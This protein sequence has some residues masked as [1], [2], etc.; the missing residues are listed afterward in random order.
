MMQTTDLALWFDP[1]YN[2]IV[3]VGFGD[4][5]SAY[6]LK[7]CNSIDASRVAVQWHR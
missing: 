7:Q 4:S 1:A 3:Q 2:A 6:I 5:F